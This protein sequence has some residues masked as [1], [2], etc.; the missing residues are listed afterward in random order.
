[1][2]LLVRGPGVQQNRTVNDII[3]NIDLAPTI[4]EIGGGQLEDADGKSFLPTLLGKKK[5]SNSV[6]SNDIYVQQNGKY[7]L[8][9][10]IISVCSR[11]LSLNIS[12]S[13]FFN[14]FFVIFLCSMMKKLK[15]KKENLSL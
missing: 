10:S 3:V 13:Y 14:Q 15:K 5:V 11:F 1:M 6:E 4:V 9:A 12:I 2:P 8:I 7:I